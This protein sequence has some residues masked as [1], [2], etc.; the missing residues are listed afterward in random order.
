[1]DLILRLL[2]AVLPLAPSILPRV[3]K[4]WGDEGLGPLPPDLAR[5]AAVDKAIDAEI[6]SRKALATEPEIKAS[7]R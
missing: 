4:F 1:M 6:A 3:V 5:W 2:A 7:E